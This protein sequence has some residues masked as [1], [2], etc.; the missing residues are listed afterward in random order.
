MA[1]SPRKRNTA[2]ARCEF[3][4]AHRLHEI[5]VVTEG[6]GKVTRNLVCTACE[7]TTRLGVCC[8]KCGDVRLKTEYTKHR[9]DTTV[10]VK[11]CVGCGAKCRAK[12]V[13][14]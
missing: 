5:R 1:D 10:R 11:R 13:L 8:P 7:R 4:E 14:L 9:G 3:C 12:E 6:S 2:G